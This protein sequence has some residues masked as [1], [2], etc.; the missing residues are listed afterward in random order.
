MNH[1]VRRRTGDESFG[2]Q[3]SAFDKP[4]RGLGRGI[5]ESSAHLLLHVP[6]VRWK[7]A[8]KTSF[9]RP[10]VSTP[11]TKAELIRQKGGTKFV[12]YEESAKIGSSDP[13]TKTL[14]SH[15]RRQVYVR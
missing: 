5:V 6:Y 10:V 4:G 14:R 11:A 15:L 13:H 1:R 3:R 2:V 9:E 8:K 7:Q 12:Q